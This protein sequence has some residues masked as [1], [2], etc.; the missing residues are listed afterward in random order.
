MREIELVKLHSRDMW[1]KLL[2]N[3]QQNWALIELSETGT[4]IYFINDHSGVFDEINCESVDDAIE[5]L[6]RNDFF[7]Y[8]DKPDIQLMHP[9]PSPP[10][11]VGK[12]P[13]GRIYSS[14]RYWR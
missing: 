4:K 10:Y 5:K 6:S 13:N 8:T 11:H 2:E 7:R 14:G 1:V 3:M 9:P 12:H